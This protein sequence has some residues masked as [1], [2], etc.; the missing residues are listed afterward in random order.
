ML[1]TSF[2]GLVLAAFKGRFSPWLIVVFLLLFSGRWLYQPQVLVGESPASLPAIGRQRLERQ[3]VMMNKFDP[4]SEDGVRVAKKVEEIMQ[5]IHDDT[6][7]QQADALIRDK[8]YQAD[9]LQIERLSGDSDTLC[10]K[11]CYINL[12]IVE[13]QGHEADQA[14][15]SQF[16]LLAR[17]KVE[18]A[19]KKQGRHL[20][21]ALVQ[22]L[23]RTDSS[24]TLFLLDGLD[25]VSE[26]L[27]RDDDMAGFPRYLRSEPNVIITSRPN[28]SLLTV[29]NI[30]LELETIGF[31]PDQVDAYL[32]ADPKTEPKFEE[33]KEFLDQRWLVRSLVRIPI[34]LGALCF[35]W[36]DLDSQ[37]GSRR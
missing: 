17:Q 3:H 8:Q 27:G 24:R 14:Q 16:S 5:K 26:L 21:E 13:Q 35:T 29:K 18:T 11:R 6:P 15:S 37:L 1:L 23:K 34:Q 31:N 7:L 19:E 25:E 22:E 20:A 33:I 10:M 12:A 4:E 30:D 9:R 36:E 2:A 28:V 32:K